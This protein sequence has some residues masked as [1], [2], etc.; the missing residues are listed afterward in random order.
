MSVAAAVAVEAVAW[1]GLAGGM[2]S[3]SLESSIGKEGFL[4]VCA[5]VQN[6]KLPNHFSEPLT[7]EDGGDPHLKCPLIGECVRAIV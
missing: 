3:F 5:N 7:M 4:Y 2:P 1:T 6:S